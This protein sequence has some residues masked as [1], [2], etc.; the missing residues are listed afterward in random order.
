MIE[1]GSPT[2]AVKIR[3]AAKK[4]HGIRR[5]DAKAHGIRCV[6]A[7]IKRPRMP[8][9]TIRRRKSAPTANKQRGTL[10]TTKYPMYARAV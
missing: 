4:A 1:A 2:T 8:Y 7:K 5:V 10:G 6:D 3:E 9:A